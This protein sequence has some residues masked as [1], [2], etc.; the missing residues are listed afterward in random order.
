[1]RQQAF[2]LTELLVTMLISLLLLSGIAVFIG[3]TSYDYHATQN[4]AQ[5]RWQLQRNMR[6]LAREIMEA[7]QGA[8][9]G[10]Q[11]TLEDGTQVPF[12]GLTT[13]NGFPSVTYYMTDTSL[14][15]LASARTEIDPV[16]SVVNLSY[17]PEVT[18]PYDPEGTVPA[19]M[20]NGVP[21]ILNVKDVQVWLGVD[22][23]DD[24]N[25]GDDEWTQTFPEPDDEDTYT[26]LYQIR[27]IVTTSTLGRNGKETVNEL[28]RDI[29]LRN[30]SVEI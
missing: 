15:E 18:N 8:A 17:S 1:M 16:Y 5:D 21:Y 24:G 27:L 13:V 14:D 23:N 2:S 7:G 30:R 9:T 12:I 10:Y 25:V 29:Y 22:A 6:R 4:L 11:L 26:N 19:L 28:V 20:R 3:E